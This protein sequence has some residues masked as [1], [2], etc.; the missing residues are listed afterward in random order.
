M[1]IEQIN[2]SQAGSLVTGGKT[3]QNIDGDKT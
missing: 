3:N 1:Q 2:P